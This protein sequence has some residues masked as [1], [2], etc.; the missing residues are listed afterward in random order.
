MRADVEVEKYH[1]RHAQDAAKEVNRIES[2]VF[3]DVSASG[4]AQPD[5]LK[6]LREM[7]AGNQ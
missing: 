2:K 1:G 6:W 5:A 7:E 4:D 3:G